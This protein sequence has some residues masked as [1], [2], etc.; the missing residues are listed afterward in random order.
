MWRLPKRKTYCLWKECFI[1]KSITPQEA[2]EIVDAISEL[3]ELM[4]II[5]I[6]KP[7]K[8]IMRKALKFGITYYDVAYVE[9]AEEKNL[10][11][12][13]EDNKLYNAIKGKIK[14]DVLKLEEIKKLNTPNQP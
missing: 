3:L 12:V 11:F 14:T 6:D 4:T 10:L 8:S 1:H 7:T 5:P 2:E 9:V 13:T